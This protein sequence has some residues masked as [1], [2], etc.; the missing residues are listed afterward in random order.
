MKRVASIVLAVSLTM[1]FAPAAAQELPP[2]GT[3][4]DDDGSVHEPAIE[5]LVAAGI[6][7]GC[8][9]DLFC[10]D[11]PVTRGQMASFIARALPALIPTTRD[12]FDDDNGNVHEPNINIIAENG[13]TLGYTDGT[14]RSETAISRAEMAT[15][16]MRALGLTPI[17]P[18]PR[19]RTVAVYLYLDSLGDEP[20][21][22]GAYL[23]PVARDLP[24]SLTPATDAMTQLLAGPTSGESVSI[25]AMSS[26][27]PASAWAS[28][29]VIGGGTA[30][31]GLHG[32]GAATVRS[33]AQVVFTLTQFPTVDRVQLTVD[34]V[35]VAEVG[36]IEAPFTREDFLD[37]GVLPMVFADQP[38]F[39][40]YA[41]NPLRLV[42][43][44][45][46]FEAQFEVV[47]VDAEGLI[48]AEVPVLANGPQIVSPGGIPWTSFDVTIPYLLDATQRGAVITFD[49]SAKDGSQIGVREYPVT[50]IA[51]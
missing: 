25:P 24:W 2:G 33:V 36:G 47:I 42:G 31:V 14:Y 19:T 51:G 21:G 6:T 9:T 15:M 11:D 20:A 40:G 30:T 44:T 16:L 50:L 27:I 39:D 8:E 35:A 22:P 17:V 29:I 32:F 12:W 1:S 37:A 10:P 34:S 23:V 3:F 38:L 49:R 43:R 7:Q 4:I 18:L 48:V 5:A 46:A 41:A 28:S 26:A 45:F 13:I